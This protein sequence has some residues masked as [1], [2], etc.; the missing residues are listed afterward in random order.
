MKRRSVL[1][2]IAGLAASGARADEPIRI[3]VLTDM[4]GILANDMGP[5][6]VLAARMAVADAG[7]RAGGR[8][9]EVVAGDHQQK[10]DVGAAIAREWFDSGVVAIFD[11]PNSAIALGVAALARAR[12]RLF[13][14]GGASSSELTDSRCSPN[15]IAWAVDNYAIGHGTGA[16]VLARGGRNWFFLTS[17]YAFGYDLQA[18]AED[19]VRAGGGRIAG[20]TKVPLGASDFSSFLLQ[21]QQS[22]ADVLMVC[23]VGQDTVNAVKQAHE[24]GLTRSMRIAAPSVT[25][26]DV[27]GI[28]LDV[29]AGI[30]KVSNFDWDLN[31]GTRA[32]SR[33]FAE[34]L[35][36][37]W[38]PTNLQAGVYSAVLHTMK[39]LNSGVAPADGR[40]L[41]DA[42]KKIRV[43]DSVFGDAYIRADGRVMQRI[44]LL[45]VKAPG[46]PRGEWDDFAVLDAIAPEQAFRPPARSSCPLLVAR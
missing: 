37:H 13:V 5:G 9:V 15:T 17:D 28:G 38:P 16:A 10:P 14:A 26:N 11:V 45:Q 19:A 34:R 32:F 31:D 27:R 3:G 33:R 23:A 18:Q 22:Q 2:A 42:M 20:S 4:N 30:L 12:N 8:A 21:A 25:L 6:S 44:Y 43:N 41:A 36:R 35:P 40:A 29:A 24:F 39:A 46:Q 7:G 1:A